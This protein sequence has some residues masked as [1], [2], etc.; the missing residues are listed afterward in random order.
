MESG[1]TPPI[2]ISSLFGWTTSALSNYTVDDLDVSNVNGSIDF[3]GSILDLSYRPVYLDNAMKIKD[4]AVYIDASLWP[5]L[6]TARVG[7]YAATVSIDVAGC[8][9]WQIY[10]MDT[11]PINL[12][13][14]VLNGQQVADETNGC[15]VILSGDSQN[16]C[17]NPV[18]TGNVLTYDVLHFDGT[19]GG[20]QGGGPV[21]IPEFS[22]VGM[23]IAIVVIT[24]GLI[25]I[26]KKRK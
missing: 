10:H 18:C 12:E 3:T 22:T 24:A 17:A 6:N 16:Y 19:G 1:A 25:L 26:V 15:N 8:D 14:L 9:T 7:T 11:E 21:A 5:E 20:G 4:G 13:D 2:I 23:I